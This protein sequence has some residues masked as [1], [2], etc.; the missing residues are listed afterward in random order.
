MIRREQT[1]IVSPRRFTRLWKGVWKMRSLLKASVIAGCLAVVV[2]SLAAQEPGKKGEPVPPPKGLVVADPCAPTCCGPTCCGTTKVCVPVCD[3][4]KT[5][6]VVFC[7]R[8]EDFCLP[9]CSFGGG[10]FGR[11]NSCNSC[12]DGCP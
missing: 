4:K 11:C 5:T 3:V 10:L 12:N 2:G 6:R 1:P 7:S 8:C 9:R